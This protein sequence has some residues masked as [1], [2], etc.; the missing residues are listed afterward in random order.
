MFDRAA[1]SQDVACTLDPPCPV[2]VRHAT[3]VPP[4]PS[5][6]SWI[7]ER[8]TYSHDPAT[9]A[10]VAQFEPIPA[11][12]PL[13]DQRLVT[14][15]YTRTRSNLRGANGSTET[16]YEVQQWGN[17]RGGLDAEWERFHDAWK[18][19]YLTGGYYNQN[20]GYYPGSNWNGAPYV[21]PGWGGYGYNGPG[22]GFPGYGVPWNGNAGPWTG[23]P[24]NGGPWMGGP[25]NGPGPGN[26]GPWN[27]GP[28]N[29]PPQAGPHQGGPHQHD[30]D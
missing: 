2:Y 24:G 29:G 22:Y 27:N 19:S 23:G 21:G 18:E 20:G 16:T 15:R 14:S 4:E 6:P 12:E 25:G 3:V 13:E 10:R 5:P 11:V 9:G 30:N 8:S 1:H 17:G 28:G 26:G 7:F